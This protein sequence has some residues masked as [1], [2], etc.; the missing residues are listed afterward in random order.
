MPEASENKTFYITTPIYYATD[1][2]HI[3]H[4]YT[5]VIGDALARWHRL[6]GEDVF[7][8]TGTDEHGLKMQRKATEQGI[9]PQELADKTS[10][11]YRETWD[12]LD[13]SYDQFIRTTEPRHYEAV[14]KFLQAVYDAGDIEL[15]TYSGLYCVSCEDYYTEDDAPGSN[16]PIHNK[17]IEYME[18]ENYFFLLSKYEQKMLDWIEANPDCVQPETR[19]NEVIGFIKTGL[20]RHFDQSQLVQLGRAPAVGPKARGLGLV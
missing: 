9:T 10:V 17:P 19:K 18:E 13:I 14:S 16:C 6:L 2:P 7:Y 4:T 11:R 1:V 3:G 20:Q 8:L 15:R 12:A 5:T